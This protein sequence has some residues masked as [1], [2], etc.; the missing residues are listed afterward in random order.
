MTT[1]PS[2]PQPR[3][4]GSIA[5]LFLSARQNGNAALR[6][7]PSSVYAQS[8]ASGQASNHPAQKHINHTKI[9]ES[10]VASL[11]NSPANKAEVLLCQSV[12]EDST[13]IENYLQIVADQY[14]NIRL[15]QINETNAELVEHNLNSKSQAPS[16]TVITNS[17]N[18]QTELLPALQELAYDSDRLLINIAYSFLEQHR[19]ILSD[20]PYITVICPSSNDGVLNAYKMIKWLALQVNF[21]K[22]ISVYVNGDTPNNSLTEKIYNKLSRTAREFLGIKLFRKTANTPCNSQTDTPYDAQPQSTLTKT[23][24]TEPADEPVY[25]ET[26]PDKSVYDDALI[27]DTLNDHLPDGDVP[28]EGT[29]KQDNT[30]SYTAKLPTILNP[31]PVTEWPGTD[32]ELADIL[33]LALPGWLNTIPMAITIPIKQPKHLARSARVLVD[34]TGRL[35]IMWTGLY[36]NE[37]TLADVLSL[38]TW[39]AD[40]LHT[41][42][43][44]CRQLRINSDLPVGIA[45]VSGNNCEQLR[46]DT[47]SITD[48]PC[49]IL[50]L[51]L[52]QFETSKALVI[53]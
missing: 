46:A 18:F 8:P 53:I 26:I 47:Q 51:Y 40:S 3:A 22:H 49:E 9:E 39:L 25:N 24:Q 27:E 38:R 30:D 28:Q 52:M 7:P 36:A 11:L 10:A 19:E 35:W 48:F 32:A 1:I 34:T 33:Q 2:E 44:Q 16:R 29:C 41:I 4:I 13:I 23:A 12:H 14:D 50:Q 6:K 15:V 45:L 37:H 17:D 42:Q 21:P 31:V 43:Q 20:F 5:H